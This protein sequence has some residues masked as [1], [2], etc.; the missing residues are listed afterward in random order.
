ML[1]P[2]PS[3]L[4]AD[5]ASL[6]P[7]AMGVVS[8]GPSIHLG[9]S[10]PHV[11]NSASYGVLSVR[12][13]HSGSLCQLEPEQRD[14]LAVKPLPATNLIIVSAPEEPPLRVEHVESLLDEQLLPPGLKKEVKQYGRSVWEVIE[15]ALRGGNGWRVAK[16]KRPAAVT[17]TEEEAL[18][19]VG[20]RPPLAAQGRRPLARAPTRLVPRRPSFI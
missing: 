4:P 6:I 9:S 17:Y 3:R 5:T 18:N 14:L 10:R 13:A 12:W 8:V 19:P 20:Q 1:P 16:G 7:R 11:S 15:M 2:P